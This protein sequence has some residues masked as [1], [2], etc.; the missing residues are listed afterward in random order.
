MFDSQLLKSFVF[1]ADTGSITRAAKCLNLTQSAVSAQI[2][3]LEEQANCIL[4]ERTTRSQ[5]LTVQGS[6][7]LDYARNILAL[8]EQAMLRIGS[9]SHLAGTIKLGCSEGFI[10]HWLFPVIEAFVQE[11]SDIEVQITLGITT[12]L[13]EAVRRGALDIVVGAICEDIEGAE[14]LWS[15]PLLWAYARNKKLDWDKPLPLA[16]F[17]EPCPYRKAAVLK[18]EEAGAS[19]RISC[20]SPSLA[21]VQAA[22]SAGLAITP[23]ARSDLSKGLVA[24]GPNKHLPPLPEAFF[25]IVTAKHFLGSPTHELVTRIRNTSYH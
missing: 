10:A 23:I 6:L 14:P 16:F 20:T 11:H 8:N 21:G 2:R 5:S 9:S 19:W 22:A 18:L 13:H 7:L 15:E 24:I 12:S 4:L 25:A 17:P 3:K 1:V